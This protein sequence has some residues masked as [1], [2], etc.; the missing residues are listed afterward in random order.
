MP[1]DAQ[2]TKKPR[3][4]PAK[5][6]RSSK[7]AGSR[8]G[9]ARPDDHLTLHGSMTLDLWESLD[10]QDRMTITSFE[11]PGGSPESLRAWIV[12]LDH[13]ARLLGEPVITLLRRLRRLESFGVLA[14]YLTL[15]SMRTPM[16][17]KTMIAISRSGDDDH[18]CVAAM[19][20]KPSHLGD[21]GT[22]SA[23]DAAPCA[24]PCEIAQLGGAA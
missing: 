16:T 12:N 10:Q 14:T 19:T 9:S 18:L 20:G 6:R 21:D 17:G 4:T 3:P 11:R 5:G 13:A 2:Q 24:A 7:A 8:R 22:A 1:V 15:P 23:K